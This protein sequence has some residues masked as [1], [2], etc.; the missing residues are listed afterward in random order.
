MPINPEDGHELAR[1]LGKLIT[2]ADVAGFAKV[3]VF[4]LLPAALVVL[5]IAAILVPGSFALLR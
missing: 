2:G 3:V 1:G 4:V 5:V